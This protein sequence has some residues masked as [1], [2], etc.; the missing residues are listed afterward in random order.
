MGDFPSEDV[1]SKPDQHAWISS[2][3]NYIISRIDM[4]EFDIAI[5]SVIQAAKGQPWSQPTDNKSK[6]SPLLH[7]WGFQVKL[8][9]K[10]TYL[11]V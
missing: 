8:Y 11:V 4:E 3:S 1:F 6:K 5:K 10:L 9:E 2:N 7:P